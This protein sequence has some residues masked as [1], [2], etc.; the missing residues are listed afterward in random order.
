M[1]APPFRVKAIFD[2]SSPHDDDLNFSIGQIITVTEEEDSDWYSGE[3]LDKSGSKREGIFPRNFVERYEPATPPRPTKANRPSK[4]PAASLTAPSTSS[5]AEPAG[6]AREVVRQAEPPV[7]TTSASRQSSGVGRDAQ[8]PVATDTPAADHFGTVNTQPSNPPAATV[9]KPIISNAAKTAPPVADKPAGGS[10][11][12]RIAAFNK[13][14]A[15]PVAPSK[16]GS[17]GSSSG[18]SFIKKPFVAPPPSKNAYVP[19]PRDATQGKPH[20]RDDDVQPA[21]VTSPRPD[22]SEGGDPAASAFIPPNQDDEEDHPK[23]TSLKD[24]IALLQKQQLEQAARHSEAN[25]KEKAK[26]PSQRGTEQQDHGLGIEQP[27]IPVLGGPGNESE[28]PTTYYSQEDHHDHIR[29]SYDSQTARVQSHATNLSTETRDIPSDTNDAD[30][31]AAGETTEDPEDMSTGHDDHD[32]KQRATMVSPPMTTSASNLDNTRMGVERIHSGERVEAEEGLENEEGDEVEE[33]EIDP[34]VKR[35]MEIR[36]RMAKMSG[37]MGMHGM[38]GPPPGA[39]PAPS[40]SSKQKSNASEEKRT[41]SGHDSNATAT[42]ASPPK[43]SAMPL[44]PMPGMHSNMVPGVEDRPPVV[45][46]DDEGASQPIIGVRNAEEVPDVED[47]KPESYTSSNKA[48]NT[49]MAS[50]AH[51]GKLHA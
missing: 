36:E 10:F 20:R 42:N 43:L 48:E 16:P 29:S 37:G 1:S 19:P 35:R 34:A 8:G 5:E 15:P 21:I 24:R 41:I 31:S 4:E 27:S 26:R 39:M 13:P 3:Y 44:R 22:D 25:K 38:F 32:E 51:H 9:P 33:E 7:S 17:L 47:V 6:H 49:G 23:P 45:E 2:Y 28:E 30:Q 18:S 12:D 50:E 14:T 46:R 40:A 11:R